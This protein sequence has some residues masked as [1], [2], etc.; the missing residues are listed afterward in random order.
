MNRAAHIILGV[1]VSIFII[2]RL[3]PTLQAFQLPLIVLGGGIGSVFPDLDRKKGHRRILHNLFSMFFFSLLFFII[4]LYLKIPLMIP[5]SFFLGYVSH[6]LGD[7]MTYRGVALLYPFK[8]NYYRSP[9][10]I[11]RSGDLGVNMLGIALGLILMFFGIA[12]PR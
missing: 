12:G 7:M 4:S 3:S 2:S 6:L 9:L 8:S 10:V 5:T 11:G 1:G